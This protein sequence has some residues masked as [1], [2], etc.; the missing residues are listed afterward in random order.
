[1]ISVSS[2]KSATRSPVHVCRRD[3]RA[4][5]GRRALRQSRSIPYTVGLLGSIPRLDHRVAHLATIEGMVP[6]MTSPPAACRFAA[7]CPIRHRYLHHAIA[8]AQNGEPRAHLALPARAA[9]KAGVVTALL[10]VD[11]LVKHFVAARNVFG[12]PRAFVKAVTA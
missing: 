4:R 1:M 7:R 10:E 9:G 6:N 11:N 3:R 12:R 8:A 2:P 5:A